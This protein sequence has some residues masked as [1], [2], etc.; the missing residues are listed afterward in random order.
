MLLDYSFFFFF[1]KEA[2]TFVSLA[3]NCSLFSS[4]S[5]CSSAVWCW[6][7]C[8]RGF[9]VLW[10]ANGCLLLE[11]MLMTES[12]AE[13]KVKGWKQDLMLKCDYSSFK[14]WLSPRCNVSATRRQTKQRTCESAVWGGLTGQQESHQALLCLPMGAELR[15]DL[16][17]LRD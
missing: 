5:L 8:S 9:R 2:Q 7:V 11:V 1:F 16:F 14:K 15:D 6:A 13:P 17:N 4:E 10:G 3:A 12:W